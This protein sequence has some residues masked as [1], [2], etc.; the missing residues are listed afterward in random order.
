MEFTEIEVKALAA[1]A[2]YCAKREQEDIMGVLLKSDA[3]VVFR[4][5]HG[6]RGISN[7]VVD[8]SRKLKRVLDEC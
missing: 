8:L 6:Q 7:A 4:E 2:Q 5:A 3:C 1:M